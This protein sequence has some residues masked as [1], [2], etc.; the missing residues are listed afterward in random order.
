MQKTITVFDKEQ[1]DGEDWPPENAKEFL[2]WFT[3]KLEQIP[4]EHRSNAVIKI[5]SSQGL[6]DYCY[7][8]IIIQYTRPETEKDIAEREAEIKRR[9]DVIESIERQQFEILKAKYGQ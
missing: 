7:A 1:Y 4:E 2:T 3:A 5:D 8:R 9:K 6:D